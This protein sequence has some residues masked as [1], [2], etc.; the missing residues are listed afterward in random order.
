MQTAL[1]IEDVSIGFF[2]IPVLD[3]NFILLEIQKQNHL[4]FKKFFNDLYEE[5]VHYANGY[6]FDNSQSK[7]IVQ[8]VFIHLWEKSETYKIKT[9]LKGYLYVMVR[10]RCLNFLKS[11]RITDDTKV[12]EL[13]A[14]L[15]SE[16]DLETF[17][18]DDR[19][20][21]YH[22]VFKIVETLPEKMQLIVKLRFVNN[23]K[24]A[25]IAEELGISVNT[26]KTQLKR[27]KIKIGELIAS[28][29]VLLS[30]Q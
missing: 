11:I 27:A 28:L 10:N 21:V 7:D 3:H 14:I 22:Q 15:D 2:Y 29:L 16:Y 4:V 8:E 9:S 19:K 1:R 17:S 6:L 13:H 18:V 30:M 25:E 12:L 23:Y 24:Y 26:V 20:I 5:L